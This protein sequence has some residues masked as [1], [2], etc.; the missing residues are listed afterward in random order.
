[1][2]GSGSAN[3]RSIDGE[4]KHQ[5]QERQSPMDTDYPAG[6][7][8][9]TKDARAARQ[10]GVDGN[11]SSNSV[12]DP[13][14]GDH[15]VPGSSG[16]RKGRPP[17]SSMKNGQSSH[18][19]MNGESASSSNEVGDGAKQRHRSQNNSGAAVAAS[20][21]E[22]QPPPLPLNPP[23]PLSLTSEEINFLLY[24]YLQECGFVHSSFTFAHESG[25][26]RVRPRNSSSIPPGALVMFLQKGLQYVGM[27]ESLT[28]ELKGESSSSS[29]GGGATTT[30][31]GE[32]GELDERTQRRVFFQQRRWCYHR[33]GGGGR[34]A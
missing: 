26:G 25:V 17:K 5:Q 16:G 30:P 22:S 31:A 18:K 27:E 28:R 24:R 13:K 11:G 20:S 14:N 3:K 32:G 21:Q 23:A 7:E 9:D 2:A 4:M 15:S 12:R 29:S 34:R 6:G 8:R 1:M 33:P 19:E 10:Q